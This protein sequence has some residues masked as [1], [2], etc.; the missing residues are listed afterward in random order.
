MAALAPDE[1]KTLVMLYTHTTLVRGE[2][3]TKD[4]VRV[5]T[6]LRTEAAPRYIP[7]LKPQVLSFGGAQVRSMNYEVIYVPATSILAFHLVPPLQDPLDYDENEKNRAVETASVSV[8]YFIFKGR[9][10][11]YAQQGFGPTLDLTRAIWMSM[12]E[13]DI[14]NPDLAQMPTL[15]VPMLL[16][17]PAQVSF[18]VGP[19]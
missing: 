8:G 14:T 3:V 9:I 16:I 2:V 17:N 5:S 10:N 1:K 13:T 7:V 15:H 12:Y 19:A 18:A 6:W 4:N 11:Y